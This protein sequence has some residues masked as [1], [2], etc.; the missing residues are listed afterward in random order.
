[1]TQLE[2]V[3]S[4]EEIVYKPRN[5]DSAG[6]DEQQARAMDLPP[7]SGS[8]ALY[9]GSREQIAIGGNK[10]LPPPIS[11]VDEVYASKVSEVYAEYPRAFYF[12]AF[13]RERDAAGKIV[14]GGEVTPLPTADA[15]SPNYPVPANVAH[16]NGIKGM[17]STSEG[18]PAII[19]QH[20]Y[21]TC[22]VP[23]GWQ[24][25]DKIDLASC[26]KQEAELLK[27]GWVKSPNE[28]N[29]PKPRTIEEESDE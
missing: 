26:R 29:L 20:L 9:P 5:R 8:K 24:V 22:L 13:K 17:L 2:R 6:R 7:A 23:S 25:G 18:S 14:P 3:V 16:R 1:M 21:R 4:Q 27:A 10:P 19:G 11:Q 28:L 12:R 15:I